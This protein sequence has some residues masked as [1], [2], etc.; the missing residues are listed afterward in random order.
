M[1]SGPLHDPRTTVSDDETRGDTPS[2]AAEP[3][4]TDRRDRAVSRRGALAGAS[5]VAGVALAG[6][7]GR[8][9]GDTADVGSELGRG[10]DTLRW[11][12]PADAVAPGDES[13]GIG[14]ASIRFRA[15]DSA[16]NADRVAPVLRFRLNS[17]VADI[18]AGESYQ[19]YRADWFRFWVGVP[20]TYREHA[21]LRVSV[22]PNAWPEI[23]TT[24]GYR[25]ALRELA[26]HAPDV[27]EP[28]TVVVE[29][30]FRSPE[31]TLPR[32]LHCGFEVQAS[33][34]G[35][36]GRTVHVRDRAVFDAAELDLPEGVSVS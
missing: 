7:A 3:S 35:L 4:S 21:G 5:A 34:S 17:T 20:R 26:V 8:L 13:G 36:L 2:P 9:P 23:E 30:Q 33:R 1:P 6:C 29:G 31:E 16:Q 14:Y 18:A 22:E 24:Y 28:G 15:L 19:D 11:E 25:N 10:D 12:Y 32:R 27:R